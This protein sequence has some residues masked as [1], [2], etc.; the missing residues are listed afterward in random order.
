MQGL[1]DA[2]GWDATPRVIQPSRSLAMTAQCAATRQRQQGRL[3]VPAGGGAR[4]SRVAQSFQ[5]R[6]FEGP[7]RGWQSRSWG[8][9][10]AARSP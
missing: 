10:V 3:A 1:V 6:Q 9:S 4:A 2:A 5:L 7:G 8:L